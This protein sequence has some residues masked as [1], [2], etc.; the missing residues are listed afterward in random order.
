MT[1]TLEYNCGD[2]TDPATKPIDPSSSVFVLREIFNFLAMCA[3][4]A[5]LV[6]LCGDPLQNLVLRRLRGQE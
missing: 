2:L 1:Q 5:M 4:L 3:M 6:P